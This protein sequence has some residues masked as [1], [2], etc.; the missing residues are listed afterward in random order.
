MS[1]DKKAYIVSAQNVNISDL[2]KWIDPLLIH[3]WLDK[4]LY[5]W[6]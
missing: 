3:S 6:L 2:Q 5:L 1:T 4:N